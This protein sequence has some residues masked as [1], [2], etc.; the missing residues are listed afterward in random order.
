MI[1]ECVCMDVYLSVAKRES[2]SARESEREV[3]Y[4][5]N[6]G[7]SMYEPCLPVFGSLG[8]KGAGGWCRDRRRGFKSQGVS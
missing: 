5:R 6:L 8:S 2:E 1:R 4:R 7:G 3:L